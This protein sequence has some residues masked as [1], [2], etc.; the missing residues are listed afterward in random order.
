MNY[1]EKAWVVHR[2]KPLIMHVI[3]QIKPQVS[4]LVIS[5]NR[6]DPRY[7]TIPYECVSDES[8]TFDGPLAGVIACASRVNTDHTLIVPC[9]TPNLPD[10][11]VSILSEHLNDAEICIAADET[12]DQPLIMLAT[13]MCLSTIADYLKKG[14]RSV[15]GWLE[16]RHCNKA[17]FPVE[18]LNNINNV[19]ELE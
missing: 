10:N 8:D 1:Q 14:G 15:H 4:D 17:N 6:S 11:L 12:R 2:N 3:E 7:D 9:D 19:S 16:T 18:Q 5:R 13:T